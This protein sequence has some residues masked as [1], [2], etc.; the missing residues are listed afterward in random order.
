MVVRHGTRFPSNNI[1]ANISELH[2]YLSINKMTSQLKNEEVDK[3][4]LWTFKLKDEHAEKIIEQGYNDMTFL[5]RNIRNL[6]KDIFKDNFNSQDF[7]VIFINIP[8]LKYIF[9]CM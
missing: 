7:K 2:N 5:G 4:N 8:I 6:Y 1:I 3:L 9:G